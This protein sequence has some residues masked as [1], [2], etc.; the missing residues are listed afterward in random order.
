[1]HGEIDLWIKLAYTAMLAVIVPVYLVSWGWR[2]FLW[3]SDIA[4]VGAGI[5]LWLENSLLASM[6]AQPV[7]VPELRWNTSYF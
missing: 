4:L 2:N 1:M 5:A 7:L 6:K 3:F